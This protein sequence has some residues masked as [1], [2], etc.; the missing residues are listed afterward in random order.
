MAITPQRDDVEGVDEVAPVVGG[1]DD[2]LE[3]D[4]ELADLG[5]RS[6]SIVDPTH[7]DPRLPA[8]DRDPD[9]ALEPADRVRVDALEDV[10]V[11]AAAEVAAASGALPG[12]VDRISVI[13][14]LMSSEPR[15]ERD[16]ARRSTRSGKPRPVPMISLTAPHQLIA[17]VAPLIVTGPL[18]W[19]LHLVPLTS[20]RLPVDG[21]I[22]P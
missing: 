21:T 9:L 18:P 11:D 3:L 7:L 4:R 8:V 16:R 14:S 5:T 13:A 17:T 15:D 6:V 22:E 19:Q 12:A 20:C 2:V 1:T 10:V